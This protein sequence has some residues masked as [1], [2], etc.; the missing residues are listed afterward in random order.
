DEAAVGAITILERWGVLRADASQMYRMHDA[1]VDFAREELT[2]WE[3]NRKP[4]VDRWTKH[5]S[6]LEVAISI[7][8]YA[9]LDMWR[10]LE[11]VGGKGWFDSRPYDDQIIQMDVSNPSKAIA[12]LLVAVLYGH[13]RKF[14][15]LE[16]IVEKIL[17]Q[18][19]DYGGDCCAGLQMVA[20]YLTAYSLGWQGRINE[21]AD[22]DRQLSE[23]TG[24]ESELQLPN[25]GA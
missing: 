14:R 9:L 19:D 8:T 25:E 20:L 11:R 10:A 18:C 16:A 15:E 1:H 5:I 3:K 13:D 12:V 4:A 21:R 24:P 7:D 17:K 6:C 23:M 22:V 2:G